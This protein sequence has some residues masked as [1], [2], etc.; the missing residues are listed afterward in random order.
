MSAMRS[1]RVPIYPASGRHDVRRRGV[2][3]RAASEAQSCVSEAPGVQGTAVQAVP[4]VVSRQPREGVGA[5]G[6]QSIEI[7]RHAIRR[8]IARVAPEMSEAE[9]REFLIYQVA[10]GHFVKSLTGGVEQHRGPKPLRLR[11]RIHQGRLITVLPSSDRW[12]EPCARMR[13]GQEN[14]VRKDQ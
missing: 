6:G 9:A 2:P 13:H 11:L 5:R 4:C 7:T 3:C 14:Q 1:L 12:R 8:L 10:R